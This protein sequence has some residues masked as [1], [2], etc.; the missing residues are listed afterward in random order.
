MMYLGFE[1][2]MNDSFGVDV[3]DT[4]E[5]FLPNAGGFRFGEVLLLADA[6]QQLAALQQFHDD[7]SVCLQPTKPKQSVPL[8]ISSDETVH[9]RDSRKGPNEAS[10]K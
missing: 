10:G 1:I 2:A 9:G 5:Q 6:L 3:I 7:V 4:G 8:K